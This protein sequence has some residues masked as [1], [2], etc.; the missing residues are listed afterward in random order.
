[1]SKTL[2][3]EMASIINSQSAIKKIL[4]LMSNYVL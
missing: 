2:P 1:M 4:L 3:L